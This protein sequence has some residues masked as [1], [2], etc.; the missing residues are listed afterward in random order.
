MVRDESGV[1]QS[2]AGPAHRNPRSSLQNPTPEGP[3]AM[4]GSLVDPS[5]ELIDPCPD[6]HAL[7]LEFDARF[8]Q[9]ALAC[10]EVRWSPRMYSCAGICSYESRGGL[11]SIRL[12]KPLLSLRPRKDLVETLLERNRDRDGHGPHFQS[13]MRRI[14]SAAGTNITIYHTF[15]AEVALYKQHWWRCEG[16]C[17]NRRPFFGYVKRSSNRAPGPNDLWWENHRSSCGGAFIKIKEPDGYGQKRKKNQPTLEAPNNKKTSPKNTLDNYFVKTK[18]KETKIE[19]KKPI[20]PFSGPGVKLGGTSSS[21]PV[22]FSGAGRVLGGAGGAGTGYSQVGGARAGAGP[23][24]AQVGAGR[25]SILT[26]NWTRGAGPTGVRNGARGGPNRAGGVGAEAGSPETR[27]GAGGAGRS[28]ILVGGARVGA[29]PTGDQNTAGRGSSLT[30][31]W[32]G[33]A[34]PTGARSGAGRNSNSSTN[35]AGAAPT[36]SRSTIDRFVVHGE[37][38]MEHDVIVLDD[39]DDEPQ[40]NGFEK[41]RRRSS[42]RDSVEFS[43]VVQGKENRVVCPS[44]NE[45]LDEMLINAHLDHCLG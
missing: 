26:T 4:A 9:G 15:H 3:G 23:S 17:Q 28:S 18:N 36:G 24:G 42:S 38:R 14:N 34:G 6:I 40:D 1:G 11:C 27:N 39:S 16:P 32:T 35:R 10:C 19:D 45:I 5:Y 29:G 21:V 43:F 13:H 44:C 25:G 22:P 12:S 37:A 20:V 7:F 30:T 41:P 8:F 31:S 33:G 2:L